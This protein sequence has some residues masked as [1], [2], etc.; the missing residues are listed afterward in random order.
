[1][2]IEVTLF[3]AFAEYLGSR[4]L[5]LPFR[6]GITCT[7]AWN[8]IRGD[9]PKI[10][11][12]PVLF[13][14]A[15]EYVPPETPLKDGD[16]LLVF[17]PLSGGSSRSIYD[18]P[19]SIAEVLELIRDDSGGGEA[20]FIGRVRGISNGKR[21]RHLMYDCHV[22]MAEKEIEKITAEMFG[23]WP[24]RKISIQHRIGKLDVGEIAVIIAVSAEHRKEALEA[25]RFGIDEVKRRVPIWKKEVSIDGEEWVGTERHEEEF[26]D[27]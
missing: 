19:L 4:R 17:P 7:E 13:A 5:T 14:V 6:E 9:N 22:P 10:G 23:R 24:L 3:A 20:L 18:S 25:C 16:H 8:Q 26:E 15:D 21:I 27:Q 12:I 11:S 2:A 1:V